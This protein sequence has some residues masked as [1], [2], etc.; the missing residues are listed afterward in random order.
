MSMPVCQTSR[1]SHYVLS[2]SVCPSVRPSVHQTCEH[3]TLR[4]NEPI[5]MQISTSGPRGQGVKRSTLGVT[6]SKVKGH[7]RLKIDLKACHS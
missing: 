3:D 7:S 2:L 1:W 6:R 5:L 4:T